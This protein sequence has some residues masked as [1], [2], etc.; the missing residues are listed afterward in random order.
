VTASRLLSGDVADLLLF[1][2]NT[3]A[4]SAFWGLYVFT[5]ALPFVVLKSNAARLF[6]KGKNIRKSQAW[7]ALFEIVLIFFIESTPIWSSFFFKKN[8]G[9][10]F[11]HVRRSVPLVARMVLLL[12]ETVRQLYFLLV[13]QKK[14]AF[15]GETPQ[16]RPVL[17]ALMFIMML[18]YLLLKNVWL[19]Q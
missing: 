5:V 10:Y 12:P 14:I 8:L 6:I 11:P 3:W 9:Y 18:I 13:E 17:V 7:S 1:G 2:G 16:K 4:Q 19:L 15:L